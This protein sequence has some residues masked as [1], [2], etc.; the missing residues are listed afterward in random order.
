MPKIGSDQNGNENEFHYLVRREWKRIS[1][2]LWWVISEKTKSCWNCI[3]RNWRQ[4]TIALWEK[5]K[6]RCAYVRI[7]HAID[8]FATCPPLLRMPWAFELLGWLEKTRVWI[9]NRGSSPNKRG[10]KLFFL[11]QINLNLYSLKLIS[12]L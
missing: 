1:C 5:S 3:V 11:K 9:N 2:R 6:L 10:P 7:M 4:R 8:V 12:F